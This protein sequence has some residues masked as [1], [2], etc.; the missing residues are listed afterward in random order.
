MSDGG[1]VGL[2]FRGNGLMSSMCLVLIDLL[3]G[4]IFKFIRR[5]SN[6]GKKFF[7]CIN[8]KKINKNFATPFLKILKYRSK[9][10]DLLI[11]II[12]K[13]R[14]LLVIKIIHVMM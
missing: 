9:L 3:C 13:K 2:L 12:Y 4:P 6:S 5:I 1:T 11:I 10:F 7:F 14:A 8:P